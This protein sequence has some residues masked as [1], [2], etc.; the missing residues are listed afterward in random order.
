VDPV[1]ETAA[2]DSTEEVLV[3]VGKLFPLVLP[4]EETG[5]EEKV[6][7]PEPVWECCECVWE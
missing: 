2:E 7:D 6:A 4:V 3:L 5:D 1:E